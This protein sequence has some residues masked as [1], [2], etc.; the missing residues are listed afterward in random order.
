MAKVA[1][2]VVWCNSVRSGVAAALLW[3]DVTL[4]G[5]H[6]N[7][8]FANLAVAARA[9]LFAAAQSAAAQATWRTVR[10]TLWDLWQTVFRAKRIDTT[11][12]KR[13]SQVFWRVLALLERVATA[14]AL[15]LRDVDALIVVA[16]LTVETSAKGFAAAAGRRE[17]VAE[18]RAVGDAG[19]QVERDVGAHVVDAR[20]A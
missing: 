14:R 13:A 2:E 5:V 18:R 3:F 19:R 6:A 1:G 12:A 11:F 10:K 16:H 20:F 17:T 8:F 7:V 15:A 4:L 9:P